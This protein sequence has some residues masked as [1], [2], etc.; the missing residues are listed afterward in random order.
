MK[1]GEEPWSEVYAGVFGD[2]KRALISAAEASLDFENRRV[3]IHGAI[4]HHIPPRA[5]GNAANDPARRRLL[6][7][8]LAKLRGKR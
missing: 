6:A 8:L 3:N 7:T 5:F 4:W 2:G 1:Q